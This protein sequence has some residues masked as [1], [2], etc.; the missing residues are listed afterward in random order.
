MDKQDSYNP[1]EVSTEVLEYLKMRIEES[2]IISVINIFPLDEQRSE[3]LCRFLNW[4]I[5]KEINR[6]YLERKDEQE[7]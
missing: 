5:E 1:S 6:L 3:H 4:A 2:P 7:Q